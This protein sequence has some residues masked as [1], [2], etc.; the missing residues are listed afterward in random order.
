MKP[1]QWSFA[2]KVVSEVENVDPK[3]QKQVE[4]KKGWCNQPTTLQFQSFLYGNVM[5]STR[6]ES[7]EVSL[8]KTSPQHAPDFVLSLPATKQN[9]ERVEGWF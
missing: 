8:I 7:T 4:A 1:H 2:K 9:R 6:Y 3:V 5:L